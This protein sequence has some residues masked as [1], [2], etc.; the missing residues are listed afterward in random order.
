MWILRSEGKDIRETSQSGS[1][2]G[3]SKGFLQEVGAMVQIQ[4]LAFPG[5]H[6]D[7]REAWCDVDSPIA[8]KDL[9]T[10]SPPSTSAKGSWVVLEEELP[11]SESRQAS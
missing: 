11:T 10:T 2:W 9:P 3:N 6:Q 8:L 4:K 7:A 5:Q 1:L